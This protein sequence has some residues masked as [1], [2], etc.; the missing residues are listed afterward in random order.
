MNRIRH[1]RSAILRVSASLLLP[2]FLLASCSHTQPEIHA[3][4]T[5][6]DGKVIATVNGTYKDNKS[7]AE[8]YLGPLGTLLSGIGSFV[9]PH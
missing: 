3:T 4:I 6:P 2:V 1:L 8:K 7:F 5:R 9:I